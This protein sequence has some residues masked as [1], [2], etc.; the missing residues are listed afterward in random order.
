MTL[1][2]TLVEAEAAIHALGPRVIVE[3]QLVGPEAS[4]MAICDG[5]R[6][7]ALPPARDYKRVWR[8]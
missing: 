4:L 2:A 8:W 1:C 3:R 5:E 6:A 7:I